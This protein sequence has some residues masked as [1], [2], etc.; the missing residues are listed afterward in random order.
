MQ[1]LLR[2]LLVIPTGSRLTERVNGLSYEALLATILGWLN[3]LYCC[4]GPL[5]LRWNLHKVFLLLQPSLY[6]SLI[7][8]SPPSS[9]TVGVVESN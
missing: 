3:L 6:R 8:A 4:P 2:G 9:T 1:A 7:L 5:N